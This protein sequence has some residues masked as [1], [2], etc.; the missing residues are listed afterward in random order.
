MATHRSDSVHVI[1]RS[2]RPSTAMFGSEN[3]ASLGN[4][5]DFGIY[6]RKYTDFLGVA[7][8]TVLHSPPLTRV[9]FIS[10]PVRK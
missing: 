2:H 7:Q 10:F 9:G 8:P 5:P 6:Q 1:E 3:P 4:I